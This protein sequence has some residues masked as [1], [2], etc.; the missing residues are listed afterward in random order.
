MISL[1][2][3]TMP[4]A[5]TYNALTIVSAMMLGDDKKDQDRARWYGPGQVACVCD[6]LTSSPCSGQGAKLVTSFA[7][8]I[9]DDDSEDKIQTMCNLLMALREEYQQSDLIIPDGT[10]PAMQDVLRKVVQE[11]RASS[12][13]TTMVAMKIVR[14]EKTVTANILKCGDSA[15]FAFSHEGELLTSSLTHNP[16]KNR[17]IENK[18][19]NSSFSFDGMSFG[20]GYQIL[21]RVEGLLSHCKA[22]AQQT[23][24][25]YKHLKNW[26]V[27]T[28][29][30]V[31]GLG[32]YPID[33][34]ASALPRL[35]LRP[36]DHL[37]LPKYL[38]GTQLTSKGQRYRVLDYSSTIRVLSAEGIG[39]S[40]SRIAQRGSTTIVLPDHF[41]GGY[42]ESY[43]D[44]FPLG[45]HFVLCS[46]G[47]YSGF[48]DAGSLW[49]WLRGNARAL[50]HKDGK[51]AVLKRLH[52]DL[53]AKG[54]DDDIS[55]VW[56]YP[57]KADVLGPS[58]TARK[59]K[60]K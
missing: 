15:F 7:P 24:I 56:A 40:R 41:Y 8:I 6:G 37:L 45:T 59:G 34:G 31:C 4:T 29:I 54:G 25:R 38:Y 20:P 30:E 39:A 9:F 43:Q 51:K 1:D 60:Q 22:L 17:S 14:Y 48:S 47:F 19:N 23:Q 52:S 57:R 36:A 58:G 44:T 27:C 11:K 16:Y 32:T 53:E 26:L 10:S 33:K 21:V 46:D 50:L 5:N 18:R 2:F 49:K 42:V 35:F 13:Q 12:F 55:F 28:P 3:N